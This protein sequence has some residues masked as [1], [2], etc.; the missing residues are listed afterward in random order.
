MF[1]HYLSVAALTFRKSPL[2]ALA[3]VA[4]LALGL[5]AFV[6][7]YAV[8]D[9]WNGA[10][11]Q[12]ANSQ[13]T[14]IISSRIELND[15]S[16]LVDTPTTNLH[17]ANHLPTYVPRIEAVARARSLGLGGDVPV[18][19]GDR[20]VR[21]YAVAA[22]REFLEIFD[23]PFIAGDS[24]TALARPRSV[25]LTESAAERLFGAVSPLGLTVSLANRVDATVTGVVKAISEPSHL[26]RSAMASLPFDML[27][28][29]DLHGSY[30][31]GMQDGGPE[32]WFGVDSPTYVLLPADQSVT[33]A[34]LQAGV[35]AIVERHMPA[36]Q[37]AFGKLVLGVL[38]VSQILGL[39][40]SAVFL[41]GRGSIAAVL[42]LLGSLV[43]GVACL[44]YAG[45]AAARAAG[46][47]HEVGVRKAI[48]A[49]ATDVLVQHLL[50]AG[51]LTS[52]ALALAVLFVRALSP[53]VDGSLGIDLSLALSAE[54]RFLA[55]VVAVVIAVTLLA[56]AYPAFV[57]SRV[58]PIFALRAF[59][60]HVGRKMLLSVLVGVQFA[61][62]SFLSIAV[63]VIYLQNAELR[64]TGLDIATDPLLVIENRRELTDLSADTLHDELLRLPQVLAVTATALPPFT[65][66]ALPLARSMDDGAPQRMVPQYVVSHDFASVLE[67]ELLAGRFLERERADDGGDAAR[68]GPGI[69]I[70]RA[71]AEF[72][73]FATPTDAVGQTLHVPKD[74]ATMFGQGT[75]AQPMQVIGVVENKP[76][77][78]GGGIHGGVLYWPGTDLAFTIVRLSRDDVAG[79]LE[80]IDGL[81]GQLA[82]G[83]AVSRR[84]VDEIFDKE[85]AQFAR[86]A[87]AMTAL[88][89]FAVLIAIVG[90]TAMAQVAV[91]RR[92]HEIAVRKVLGAKTAPMIS[93]LLK[94]F[95]LL[96]IAASFAAWPIAFIAM[97]S[98]LDRFARPIELDITLF[99]ACFLGMLLLASLTIGAQILRAARTRPSAALRHE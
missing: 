96:V 51:L 71:L 38:P 17:I 56:G 58:R 76:L 39:G 46:R 72:F 45:L 48:G 29:M 32:N 55:F 6:A 13:R 42:W 67:L 3:N 21:L 11:K 34:E 97:Q 9:F 86:I 83:I 4:V 92:R 88:C 93:M 52:A 61:A 8:T 35:E 2:V 85:Y 81:W 15:G 19:A 31:G 73:G 99:V 59:R 60:Q 79:A 5:T 65:A 75:A 89:A 70:D 64:R 98:Y 1:G 80:E 62:A 87:D 10:E 63:A 27:T 24:P 20:A 41:G 54:P 66:G 23:L 49:R 69:V 16:V 18:S 30:F 68:N 26:A 78:F 57:L 44:N 82:P 74:F 28:S 12:F 7:T 43:L 90:V 77:A 14:F 95:A 47:A 84:F 40:A 94:G 50:E 91:A 33:A 53:V 37:A 25:V 22:D 36:Q